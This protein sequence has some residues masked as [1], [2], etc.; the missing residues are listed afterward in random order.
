MAV[1]D[2][3]LKCTY[4]NNTLTGYYAVDQLFKSFIGLRGHKIHS[5]I[6]MKK[7]FRL[8]IG[9]R[10]V[11]YV[12]ALLFP[13]MR[14]MGIKTPL[15]ECASFAAGNETPRPFLTCPYVVMPYGS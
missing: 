3:S 14:R 6:L 4:L 15:G 7:A 8:I 1:Q 12:T 5:Y 11:I 2:D 9:G 13:G 10:I